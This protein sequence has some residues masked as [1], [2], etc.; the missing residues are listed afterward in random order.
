MAETCGILTNEY[1][2][3]VVLFC[4]IEIVKSFLILY[5]KSILRK[6]TNIK[7]RIFVSHPIN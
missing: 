1:E 3:T 6:L 2:N 5:R 4:Y 7:L